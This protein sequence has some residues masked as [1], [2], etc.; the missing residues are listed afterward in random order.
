MKLS[1]E[2]FLLA[3][4]LNTLTSLKFFFAFE[5][6]SLNDEPINILE[7]KFPCFLSVFAEKFYAST[8][9]SPVTIASRFLLPVVF[10]AISETILSILPPK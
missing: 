3:G 9:N 4:G 8:V 10:T 7:T 2:S 5:T 6:I 1:F